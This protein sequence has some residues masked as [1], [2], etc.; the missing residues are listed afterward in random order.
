M[1]CDL[2][3]QGNDSDSIVNVKDTLLSICILH[4]SLS[5][6]KF[7]WEENLLNSEKTVITNFLYFQEK[8]LLFLI[9]AVISGCKESQFY[10]LPFGQ[11]VA[12]MY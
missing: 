7:Q 8:K 1:S 9:E 2:L 10:S 6:Q 11:A 4:F 5:S 3:Q 12:S